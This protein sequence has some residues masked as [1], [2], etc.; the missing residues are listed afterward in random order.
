M[1]TLIETQRGLANGELTSRALVEESLAKIADPEGEGARCFLTVYA[2]AARQQADFVDQS[3]KLGLPLA[4]FAGVPLSIKD[5]YDVAGE[6]TRAGSMVL[7]DSPPARVHAVIVQRLLAAGLVPMIHSARI[8]PDATASNMRTASYP[9]S[10]RI[11]PAGNPQIC[12]I[13]RRCSGLEM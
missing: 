12:S 10:V 11:V 9:G 6:V 8:S 5:L 7:N 4:P 3:R 13:C 1:K 2:D